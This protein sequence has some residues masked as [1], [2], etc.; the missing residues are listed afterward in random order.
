MSKLPGFF[1]DKDC[2]PCEPVAEVRNN[3][4]DF[5]K[6]KLILAVRTR[7]KPFMLAKKVKKEAKKEEV[8]S[9]THS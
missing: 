8:P 4:N 6:N 1:F 5:L 7:R 2:E 9:E 3:W